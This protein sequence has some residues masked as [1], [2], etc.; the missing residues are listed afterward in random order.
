MLGLYRPLFVC[1]AEQQ[2]TLLLEPL[3]ETV[4]QIAKW[5]GKPWFAALVQQQ[6]Q[7][8]S[9]SALV[10]PL[11]LPLESLESEATATPSHSAGNT[12]KAVPTPAALASL[13]R[14]L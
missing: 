12:W 10:S 4:W 2:D 8:P 11:F 14:K 3:L 1:Q 13:L 9:T 5:L 7:S 6:Q